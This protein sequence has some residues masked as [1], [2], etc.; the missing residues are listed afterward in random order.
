M[1]GRSFNKFLVAGYPV[2]HG[3]ALF[4][5]DS[6]SDYAPVEKYL[7]DYAPLSA[8]IKTNTSY[9]TEYQR[10]IEAVFTLWLQNI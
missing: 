5:A 1:T 2:S 4:S 9:L 6:R 7:S 10:T 8:D 3:G